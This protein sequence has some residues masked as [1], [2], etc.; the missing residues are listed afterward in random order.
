MGNTSSNH[1][2]S[3]DKLVFRGVAFCWTNPHT[4][5]K[6]AWEIWA[7][8]PELNST[9][10]RLSG[11]IRNYNSF[12]KICLQSLFSALGGFWKT[13]AWFALFLRTCT[14]WFQKHQIWKPW[15]SNKLLVRWWEKLNLKNKTYSPMGHSLSQTLNGATYIEYL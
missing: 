15:L 9:Q 3:G 2:F 11:Y 6:L 14:C 5:E 4:P 8:K 13:R 12:V 1:R 7:R 10:K